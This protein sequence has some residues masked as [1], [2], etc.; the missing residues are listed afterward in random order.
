MKLYPKLHLSSASV[1]ASRLDGMDPIV[2]RKQHPPPLSGQR[3][4]P[5]GGH[6]ITEGEMGHLRQ[7]LDRIA[8]AAGFPADSV[9]VRQQ[10]DREVARLL[11]SADLPP[12]EM[13]RPETWAWIAVHL[14]PHLVQWRFGGRDAQTTM[15]RF[16]GSLQRNAI[17]R[18][19]FRGWVFDRGPKHTDRFDLMDR[20]TEDASVAVLERTTIASDHRL[21]KILID[22]WLRHKAQEQTS[23]SELLRQVAK[24]IRVLA[25]VQEISVLDSNEVELAVG[26]ILEET[27]KVLRIAGR[28]DEVQSS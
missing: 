3:F 24:R 10:F 22:Q 28:G 21:A 6:R 23:A 4:A 2:I 11:T 18:L 7:E 26:Q 25:V 17:G 12:G 14:V 15:E 19:W 1:L 5:T 20:L 9:A 13:L 27:A 8:D 16:A